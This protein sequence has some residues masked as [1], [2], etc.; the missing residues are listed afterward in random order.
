MIG[1]ELGQH[2]L[3][4]QTCGRCPAFLFDP[5][6]IGRGLCHGCRAGPPSQSAAP[7]G[8]R[9]VPRWTPDPPRVPG[10]YL[11]RE[12]LGASVAV[13]ELTEPVPGHW[14][15]R[16]GNLN[17]RVAGARDG[18][19][20]MGGLWWPEPIRVPPEAFQFLNPTEEPT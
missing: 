17:R 15:A 7:P 2:P 1:D 18:A 5:Q 10:W 16:A 14:W 9:P 11:W 4:I 19:F 3:A 8:A 12:V 6:S 20:S 13:Y